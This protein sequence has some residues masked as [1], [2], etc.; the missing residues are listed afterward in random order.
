MMPPE[1]VQPSGELYSFTGGKETQEY[2]KVEAGIDSAA[3]DCVIPEDIAT[4]VPK[5]E[6]DGSKRGQHWIAANGGK[7]Y[8][9]GQ[10]IVP[11]ST[12]EGLRKKI[13]FQV[14]KV[15]KTLISVDRLAETGHEV[16]LSKKGPRII[17]PDGEII[18]LKRKKGIFV[19][20]MWI[21]RAGDN[22]EAGFHRP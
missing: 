14:A 4:H 2:V 8:N 3:V 5:R 7:I 15:N 10:R 1:G 20:N 18:P 6:S 22:R 13:R 17:C 16:I 21:K 11:F 9:L 12:D 19:L